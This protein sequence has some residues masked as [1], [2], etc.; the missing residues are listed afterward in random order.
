[1]QRIVTDPRQ[2]GVVIQQSPGGGSQAATGS[3]VTIT[4]GARA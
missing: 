2:Y 1:V 3:T 4:V